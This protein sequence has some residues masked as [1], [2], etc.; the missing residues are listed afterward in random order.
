VS[1]ETV[2]YLTVPEIIEIHA[3]TMESME[4]NPAPL[5]SEDLLQSAVMRPQSVAY[6]GGADLVEQA[7]NLATGISQNQ[8]FLDGNKRTAYA[9]MITF[10]D[11]NGLEVQA[12]STEIA[13][14]LIAVAEREGSLEEATTAFASGC[15]QSERM[16]QTCQASRASAYPRHP[17]STPRS[18]AARSRSPTLAGCCGTARREPRGP[19]RSRSGD[20]PA[21]R[22]RCE[23]PRAA[24]W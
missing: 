8:P 19:R 11:I 12:E 23:S 20:G 18:L 21:P 14:Q 15:M 9:A 7:A 4:T 5:R 3:Q 6:Y 17:R 10:L 13:R 24:V 22:P 16:R 1:E 2:I